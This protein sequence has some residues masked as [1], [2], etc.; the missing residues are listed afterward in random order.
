MLL[1]GFGLSDSINGIVGKQFEDLQSADLML[2]IKSQASVDDASLNQ[3]LTT[4][5][6]ESVYIRQTT[7]DAVCGN[8]TF[9]VYLVVPEDADKE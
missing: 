9:S 2:S 1:T 6:S 4:E 3:F 7:V 5:M 8:E